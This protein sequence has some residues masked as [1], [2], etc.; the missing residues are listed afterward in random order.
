[1]KPAN[2]MG[3]MNIE[4]ILMKEQPIQITLNGFTN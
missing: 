4:M 2:A 1:M 3:C